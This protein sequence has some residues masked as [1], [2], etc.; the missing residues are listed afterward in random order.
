MTDHN[1]TEG[2]WSPCTVTYRKYLFE[3]S[4]TLTKL[5]NDELPLAAKP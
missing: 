2:V 3:V 1:H 4:F 5:H